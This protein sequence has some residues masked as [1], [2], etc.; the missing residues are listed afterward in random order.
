MSTAKRVLLSVGIVM[1]ALFFASVAFS[2]RF[3][4]S[5]GREYVKSDGDR[6]FRDLFGYERPATIQITNVS[7]H[8]FGQADTLWL[9]LVDKQSALSL[10]KIATP[11]AYDAQKVPAYHPRARWTRLLFPDLQDV[12]D[13]DS[14]EA[15]WTAVCA[16]SD[17]YDFYDYTGASCATGSTNCS[18]CFIAAGKN[19]DVYI[20]AGKI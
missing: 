17:R 20:R 2:H 14:L 18:Y 11:M 4:R 10:N 7:G 3:V 12:L 8:T 6:E 9:H 5:V 1:V 19:G 13:Q 15:G 16:H